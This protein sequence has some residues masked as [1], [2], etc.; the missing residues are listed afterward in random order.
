MVEG[1]SNNIDGIFEEISHREAHDGLYE[2]ITRNVKRVL[3]G[4]LNYKSAYLDV[5]LENAP[6]RV[7]H[8]LR[9]HIRSML[10]KNMFK[11][12]GINNSDINKQLI[13]RMK[14]N[15][16]LKGKES[17]NYSDT[18]KLLAG[19]YKSVLGYGEINVKDNFF[20]LGGDSIMLQNI[21]NQL[22]ICFPE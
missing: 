17:E 22:E 16:V 14:N 10:D 12:R 21:Y 2:V 5:I 13:N 3:I 8:N 19:I 15:V 11:T 9:M 7:E 6:F 4:K 20:E 18:E 1:K